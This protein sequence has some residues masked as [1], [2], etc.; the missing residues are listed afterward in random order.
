MPLSD[1]Q[2][3]SLLK[4]FGVSEKSVKILEDSGHAFPRASKKDIELAGRD[5]QRYPH[6]SPGAGETPPH[7]TTIRFI[8][9]SG[10]YNIVQRFHI[11]IKEGKKGALTLSGPRHDRFRGIRISSGAIHT[12]TSAPTVDA[13]QVKSLSELRGLTYSVGLQVTERQAPAVMSKAVRGRFNL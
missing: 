12:A 9:Q 13:Q 4:S 8:K 11:H 3:F 6:F 2:I 7:I 1:E 5:T 10:D